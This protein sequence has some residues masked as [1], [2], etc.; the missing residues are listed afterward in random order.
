[1]LLIP[2]IVLFLVVDDPGED[3]S[4]VGTS[5]GGGVIPVKSGYRAPFSGR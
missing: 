1:M 4:E 2:P 3:G 5:G